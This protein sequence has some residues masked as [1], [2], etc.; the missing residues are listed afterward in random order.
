MKRTTVTL[1]LVSVLGGSARANTFVKSVPLGAQHTR[2]ESITRAWDGKYYVSIQNSNDAA[3]TDGEIVQVDLASGT[4]TPF[5]A[6][7][8]LRN[9]RGL[10][11][12][13]ELLVVTDDDKV[14]KITKAGQVSPLATSFPFPP[15]L[16]N[17]AAPEKGGKAVFVTEMGPGR[18][19][20]RD[21][22][23]LLWPTDSTQAEAIPT[24]ARV[25]R[26]TLD[27]KVQNVFTPSRKILVTNGVTQVKSGHLLALD[28]FHGSVVDIDPKKDSKSIIATG[29][30]RGCDGIEQGKDGT[31]FVTSFENGR[32]WRMD[33]TGENLVKLFDVATDQNT[34]GRQS[35]ADLTLDEAAGLL[36]VPDTLHGTIVVLKMK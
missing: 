16:F 29:P 28:F 11:F 20:M 31:I 3:A 9:P 30:F 21:P 14:W 22:N 25:Y 10:A 5:V 7:G 35:L 8:T 4:V 15:V 13:G 1:A 12:T 18:N 34:V 24:A 23:K 6:A 19:V 17:D 36:Y 32:V 26:I 27:G 33:G 2:P